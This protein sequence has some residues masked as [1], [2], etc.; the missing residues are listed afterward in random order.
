VN[1]FVNLPAATDA[2]K[3]KAIEENRDSWWK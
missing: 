1:F 2:A 3:A